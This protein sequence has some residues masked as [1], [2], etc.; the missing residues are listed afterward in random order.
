MTLKSIH[1]DSKKIQSVASKD[2]IPL[3]KMNKGK[4]MESDKIV[5]LEEH[6]NSNPSTLTKDTK[7]CKW[8]K[9][10]WTVETCEECP[11]SVKLLEFKPIY[12]EY[13]KKWESRLSKWKW[14]TKYSHLF[15]PHDF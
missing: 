6:H 10:K 9:N 11:D 15:H 2:Q 1:N 5:C 13:I 4:M 14:P 12:K 7:A 8:G 3:E